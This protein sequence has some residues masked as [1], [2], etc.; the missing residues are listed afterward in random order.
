MN[1]H[2]QTLFGTFELD[3]NIEKDIYEA[4]KSNTAK[5]SYDGSMKNKLGSFAYGLA[6]SG[7]D[8]FLFKNH[9][10][11]HGDPDQLSSTRCELL[12]I[13]ACVSYLAYFCDKYSFHPV[14][15]FSS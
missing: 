1:N 11:V 7:S 13:L 9:A 12:G 4:I 2:Y 15:S 3:V 5:M 6:P 14:L 10:P 8:Q